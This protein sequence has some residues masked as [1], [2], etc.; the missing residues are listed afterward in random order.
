[1]HINKRYCKCKLNSTISHCL[2]HRRKE[3]KINLPPECHNYEPAK[4]IGDTITCQ[5]FHKDA[6]ACKLDSQPCTGVKS[7]YCNSFEQF[8]SIKKKSAH[9][10]I[11]K[12]VKNKESKINKNIREISKLTSLNE[13]DL[14]EFLKRQLQNTLNTHTMG[15][16]SNQQLFA[17]LQLYLTRLHP[18]CITKQ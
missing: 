15:I 8:A 14:I 3:A 2:F 7:D 1:M 12:S 10:K 13:N 6:L 17:D 9:S 16:S 4:S 11:K 5:H 18:L